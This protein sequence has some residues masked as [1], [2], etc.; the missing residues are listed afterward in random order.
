[1]NQLVITGGKKAI[2]FFLGGGFHI[3]LLPVAFDILPQCP[4]ALQTLVLVLIV[5]LRLF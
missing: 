5:R 2:A 1:M 3:N 4:C